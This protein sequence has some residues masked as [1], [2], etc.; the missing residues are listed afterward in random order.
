LLLVVVTTG[1]RGGGRQTPGLKNFRASATCS[2]ILN[3]KRYIFITVNSGPTLLFRASATC[4]KTLDGKKH[5]QYS[6]N[7]QGKL[8]FSGQAQVA[9]NAKRLNNSKQMT[10]P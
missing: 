1:V 5:I 2:K 6:E 3:V 10:K 4:S 9:Q 8:C 7:F